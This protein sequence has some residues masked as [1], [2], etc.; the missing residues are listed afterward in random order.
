MRGVLGGECGRTKVGDVLV[1]LEG[2]ANREAEVYGARGAATKPALERPRGE[3]AQESVSAPKEGDGL[4]IH[5]R[6]FDRG[7]YALGI[8]REGKG[9]DLKKDVAWNEKQRCVKAQSLNTDTEINS[10]KKKA[11][12]TT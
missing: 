9:V 12:L 7:R 1:E 4:L 2:L 10:H 5:L 6:Q 8:G 3:D 11:N